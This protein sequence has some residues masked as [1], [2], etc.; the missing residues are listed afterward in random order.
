MAAPEAMYKLTE[1]PEIVRAAVESYSDLQSADGHKY[2]VY[3]ISVTDAKDTVHVLQ[4]RF[5]EFNEIFKALKG[6]HPSVAQFKFP[7][8]TLN[9]NK[10]AAQLKESRRSRFDEFVGIVMKLKPMP[11]EVRKW[12]ASEGHK[13]ATQFKDRAGAVSRAYKDK[14]AIVP[15]PDE[16]G[17][18]YDL[19]M[20][21]TTFLKF[22]RS[23]APHWRN[24]S[25]SADRTRIVWTSPNKSAGSSQV[26]VS[27]IKVVENTQRSKV[28]ER[29]VGKRKEYKDLAP[30]SLSI[31]YTPNGK[32]Q[33]ITLDVMCKHPD[34]MRLWQTGIEMLVKDFNASSAADRRAAGGGAAAAGGGGD[35]GDDDEGD[36]DGDAPNQITSACRPFTWGVGGW[37]QL[38]RPAAAGWAAGDPDAEPTSD[39]DGKVAGMAQPMVK[40]KLKPMDV[41]SAF[42]GAS[43]T[44]VVTRKEGTLVCGRALNVCDALVGGSVRDHVASPVYATGGR[45]GEM[46]PE[47]PGLDRVDR[48]PVTQGVR[49]VACGDSHTLF[50]VNT[51]EVLASGSNFFGQLG[52]GTNVVSTKRTCLPPTPHAR[53]PWLAPRLVG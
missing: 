15:A 45:L 53:P 7:S 51:G 10:D 23:G 52:T 47:L 28:F 1:A 19:M 33:Q 22:G 30:V 48:V 25:L 34:V 3:N 4:K 6:Q 44:A 38:G 49:Q 41:R 11:Q 12:L 18:I 37:G 39:A 9:F 35:D 24:F 42:C 27:E 31:Y 32:A 13:N 29:A 14:P 16:K 20:K 36:D 8:K 5:N 26:L 21:P 40:K 46:L 43:S 50:L 17:L 2:T